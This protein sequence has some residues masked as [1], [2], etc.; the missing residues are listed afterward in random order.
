MFSCKL[1][2]TSQT[3]MYSENENI[4]LSLSMAPVWL[5]TKQQTLRLC[6]KIKCHQT[7]DYSTLQNLKN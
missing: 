4:S 3:K 5:H 2:P 1:Q 7:I 6:A